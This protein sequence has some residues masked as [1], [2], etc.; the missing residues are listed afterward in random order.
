ML[1]LWFA[2]NILSQD[3][4]THA[5]SRKADLSVIVIVKNVA[6]RR[7]RGSCAPCPSERTAY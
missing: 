5:A 6:G 1:G 2:E 3:V 7:K 4:L